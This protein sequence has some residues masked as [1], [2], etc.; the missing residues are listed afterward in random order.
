MLYV[1]NQHIDLHEL[2][3]LLDGH[4]DKT[5]IVCSSDGVYLAHHIAQQWPHINCFALASDCQSR[6]VDAPQTLSHSEWVALSFQ[7]KQWISLAP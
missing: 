2:S 7:H 6:G 4:S 3:G 1:L 5:T